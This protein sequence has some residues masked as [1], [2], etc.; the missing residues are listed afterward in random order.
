MNLT[1]IFQH[2]HFPSSKEEW[3]HSFHRNIDKNACNKVCKRMS[4]TGKVQ[5]FGREITVCRWSLQ[6]GK[7]PEK[8]LFSLE[9]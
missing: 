8:I 9:Q 6:N 1:L 5:A 4:L 3:E 7:L 2:L